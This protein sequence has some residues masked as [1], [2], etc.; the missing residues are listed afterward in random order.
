MKGIACP[1]CGCRS[2]QVRHTIPE[3][4]A[5]ERYRVCARCDYAFATR[6]TFREK[7]LVSLRGLLL[8]IADLRKPG[9]AS[10]QESANS[11]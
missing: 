6:E 1:K 11:D 2:N 10:S 4:G 7:K 5:I 8:L 9:I 3:D